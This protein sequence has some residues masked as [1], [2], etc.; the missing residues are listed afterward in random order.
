MLDSYFFIYKEDDIENSMQQKTWPT[1]I[2]MALGLSKD[3]VE[4]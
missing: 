3:Q 1:T 4:Q 2:E